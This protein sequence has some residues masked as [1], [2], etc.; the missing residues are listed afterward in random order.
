MRTPADRAGVAITGSV[1]FLLVG[2]GLVV[3]GVSLV[4][5][6]VNRGRQGAQVSRRAEQLARSAVAEAMS[7][8][9]HAANLPRTAP[10]QA[11]GAILD[12]WFRVVRPLASSSGPV[13][14]PPAG[15]LVAVPLAEGLGTTEG[16]AVEPVQ[17]R[18]I[19]SAVNSAGVICGVIECTAVVRGGQGPWTAD[20]R[21][22]ERR[23]FYLLG[24]AVAGTGATPSAAHRCL[25][26]GAPL[27]RM[28][29]SL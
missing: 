4:R 10:G 16:F 5:E 7:H 24:A 6:N 26:I 14:A 27:G 2:L 28:Y 23:V 12:T 18:Y 29:E 25:V 21:L 1:L 19:I 17:A 9:A 3:G 22:T 11:A 15:G 13:P 8:I 20:R